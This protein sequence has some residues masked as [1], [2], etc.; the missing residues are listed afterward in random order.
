MSDVSNSSS[1][2]SFLPEYLAK[3]DK[4]LLNYLA[5]ERNKQFSKLTNASQYDKIKFE[6]LC[7]PDNLEIRFNHH[8]QARLYYNPTYYEQRQN[9]RY[10]NEREV[11]I[12]VATVYK[13]CKIECD[14]IK[15]LE[16]LSY[17]LIEGT[18]N[19]RCRFALFKQ[20][21]EFNIPVYT[22]SLIANKYWD[23]DWHTIADN[24]VVAVIT[25]F[26][27]I[28]HDYY[29]E[30]Y[31]NVTIINELCYDLLLHHRLGLVSKVL[32]IGLSSG[33]TILGVRDITGAC[34]Y[35][36]RKLVLE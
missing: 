3:Y 2:A 6:Y 27:T 5:W 22:T 11:N 14:D 24:V 13:H 17:Q 8:N 4:E 12:K 33:L 10:F 36:D 9:I 32:P 18:R 7:R 26:Q 1:S 16:L 34:F 20:N 23:V 25:G 19:N 28:E 15:Y 35:Q 21:L 29:W 31:A 30:I